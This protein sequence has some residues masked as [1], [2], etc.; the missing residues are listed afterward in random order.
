M[1]GSKKI[2]FGL[3]T[4]IFVGVLVYGLWSAVNYVTTK[5]FFDDES[6]VTNAVGI[7]A[8][9]EVKESRHEVVEGTGGCDV[10]MAYV[11]VDETSGL[12]NDLREKINE[13][14]LGTMA[15]FF[16][17]DGVGLDV[18]ATSFAQTC[19][20]DLQNLV[21]E[22]NDPM[23]AA[24]QAWTTNIV[25]TVHQN[26]ANIL[27]LRFTNTSD[28]G[29]AHPN[30]VTVFLT[31][32]LLTGETLSLE[33]VL[34]K[35]AWQNFEVAEKQWLLEYAKEGLFEESLKELSDYVMN[36][37][38]VMTERYVRDSL[39]Y[40]TP[41]AIG[42]FYNPYAIAPYASGPIDVVLLR[43]DLGEILQERFRINP[44][45]VQE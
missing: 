31:F 15:D 9:R 36:P 19:Q 30:T 17:A 8:L 23:S 16:P 43:S 11:L 42:I 24:Q 13:K 14:I 38:D 39:F 4:C 1:M 3:I 44:H 34:Q 7:V 20:K 41:D 26:E 5:V 33:D 40:V 28:F 37:T 45:D 27:S 6:T 10:Q 32:D 35:E 12:Q 18:A 21:K 29:G 25:T 2:F 22:M